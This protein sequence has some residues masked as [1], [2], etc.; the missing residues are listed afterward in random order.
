MYTGDPV[1]TARDWMALMM[2]VWA[3]NKAHYYAPLNEQDPAQIQRLHLAQR[4]YRLSA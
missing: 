3:L 2:P 4:L 1:Q